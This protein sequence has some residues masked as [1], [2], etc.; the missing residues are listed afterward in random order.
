MG[1]TLDIRETC[2]KP[3]VSLYYQYTISGVKNQIPSRKKAFHRN[4]NEL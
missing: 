1:H 2:T 3:R 4:D